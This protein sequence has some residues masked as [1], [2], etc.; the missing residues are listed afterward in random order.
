MRRFVQV[1]TV[2]VGVLVPTAAHAADA[3]QLTQ[4]GGTILASTANVRTDLTIDASS[5]APIIATAARDL[6]E[7]HRSPAVMCGLGNGR[8]TRGGGNKVSHLGWPAVTGILWIVRPEANS[9]QSDNGTEFNDELLGLHGNDTLRGGPGK[10]IL[11]GDQLPVGNN[12]W[13]HDVMDGGSGNDWIYS[14]HGHNDIQGGA[15]NDHIWGHYGHGT[16]DCGP[17]WDVVHTKHHSTYKLR[18]CERHLDH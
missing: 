14:S 15:G 17:G 2:A 6:C 3:Q 13:Q 18:N 12:T 16:I 1:L 9:G 10:D 4:A 11:W 5:A 7:G 8:R